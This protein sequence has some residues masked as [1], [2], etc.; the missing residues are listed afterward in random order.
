MYLV[1]YAKVVDD[2]DIGILMTGIY[3]G[4]VAD[5]Q[6]EADDIAKR[7]VSITQGGTAIPRIAKFYE[8][9]LMDTVKSMA[10]I[11]DRLADRMYDNEQT[12]GKIIPNA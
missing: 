10:K 8:G 9:H 5:S 1:L 12:I 7:C 11:F 3:V 4:G 6:Q 2:K